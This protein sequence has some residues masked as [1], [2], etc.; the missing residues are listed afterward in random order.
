MRPAVL[1]LVVAAALGAPCVVAA[2]GSTHTGDAGGFP[3]AS[4]DA[5]A[6]AGTPPDARAPNLEVDGSLLDAAC[7]TGTARALLSPIYLLVVL[8][9][10]GSMGEDGKWTSVV[11]ALEALADDLQER[12]DPS[13]GMGL[14][15][16]SDTND[17][18]MGNG[19]Y[20]TMDIPIA[21]VDANQAAAI[22]ARLDSAQPMYQTPTLAVL[23]GQY[24]AMEQYTPPPTLLPGGKKVVLFMTDGVPFPDDGGTQQDA[25]IAAAAA[26]FA[27][28]PPAGPIVTLAVGIGYFFPYDP[29]DYDP[30]FMGEL[31]VAGGAPNVPCDPQDVGDPTMFCHFQVTPLGSSGDQGGLEAEFIT[32]LDSA[33]GKVASCTLTLDRP[34]GGEAINPSLVNV[35]F[36]DD[37][38]DQ[39]VIPEGSMNGWTYDNPMAPTSVTLHGTACTALQQNPDGYATVVLGCE[40]I[41]Q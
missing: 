7:A 10:S 9:G 29:L 26:E 2:C 40:T 30:V 28:T 17:S 38:G 5:T 22:H 37:I 39:T 27:K 36:F 19:P 11:P 23:T 31:A 4:V 18:T 34:D 14:T 16:F 8:D 15:V 21:F 3:D 25:S 13:Y 32:V 6:D 12:G 1:L 33:R 35:V 24:S 41:V 20:P